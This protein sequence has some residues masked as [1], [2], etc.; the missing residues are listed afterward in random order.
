MAGAKTAPEGGG[1]GIAPQR[2]GSVQEPEDIAMRHRNSRRFLVCLPLVGAFLLLA[3]L[4]TSCHAGLHLRHQ[5]GDHR[6][7]HHGGHVVVHTHHARPR[8]V[9]IHR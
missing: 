5:H 8:R 1:T 7:H 4:T 9:V 3:S 2:G 6:P